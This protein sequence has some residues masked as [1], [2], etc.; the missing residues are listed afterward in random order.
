M[1]AW[2]GMV[3]V[4]ENLMGLLKLSRDVLAHCLSFLN[5]ILHGFDVS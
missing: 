2:L 5:R 3:S 1:L 4:L